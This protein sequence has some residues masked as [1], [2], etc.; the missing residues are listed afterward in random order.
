MLRTFYVLG[1]CAILAACGV[2]GLWQRERSSNK[3]AFGEFFSRPSAVQMFNA[4]GNKS[5]MR[6]AENSPLVAQAKTFAQYLKPPRRLDPPS[7]PVLKATLK[8]SPPAVQPVAPP[9][10]FKL[11]ATS[12]YPNQ[13]GRSMALIAELGSGLGGERWVKVGAQV[14]HFIIHE[15]RRGA[16]VYRDG[17]N[18]RE[19]AVERRAS[20]PSIVRDLRPGSVRVSAAVR[21]TD[22]VTPALA[23]PNGIEIAG[24]N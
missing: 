5:E 2:L 9:V 23:G 22:N 24:G 6:S 20:L 10:L 16:I 15:I 12:Y 19:M 4:Q 11:C 14:G 3:P 21:G 18:L 1:F 13:P 8:L 7:T 17:D